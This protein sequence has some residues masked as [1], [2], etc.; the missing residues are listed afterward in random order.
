MTDSVIDYE[1]T[2]PDLRLYSAEMLGGGLIKCPSAT[3]SARRSIYGN[4]RGRV[5]IVQGLRDPNVT[6]ENARAAAALA[7]QASN[8]EFQTLVFEDEGHGI[9]RPKNQKVLYE[10]LST[11]FGEAFGA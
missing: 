9:S 10:Q 2:C 6:P 11:F 7:L 4:I 1:T 5:L 3:A 8:V